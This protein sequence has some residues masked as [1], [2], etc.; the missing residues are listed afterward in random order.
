MIKA[1]I[2]DFD[3]VIAN[4]MDDNFNAWKVALSVYGKKLIQLDYFPL[5]GMGVKQIAV[6]FCQKFNID[7]KEVNNIILIKELFYKNNNSFKLYPFV[8]QIFNFLIK[9]KI[10]T[11][12][13]TGASKYR[14]KT[15]LPKKIFEKLDVL[16]TANDVQKTKPHPQPYVK[17]IKQ[18]NIKK[19]ECII[20]EN[21]ILGIQSAKSA[22]CLCFALK[23]TLKNKHLNYADKIFANHKLLLLYLKKTYKYENTTN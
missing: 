5:E 19:T 9:K 17:A 2:F 23:T 1:I 7:I 21:A 18:L 13:V 11:A 3:G 10:K 20:I 4:T 14:I 22:G 6:F 15:F 8:T 16:I 12:I